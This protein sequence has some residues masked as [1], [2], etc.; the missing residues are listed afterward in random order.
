MAL[1]LVTFAAFSFLPLR[2]QLPAQ[3]QQPYPLD[4]VRMLASPS[5]IDLSFLLDA[6]AGKRGFLRVANGH[7][8]TADGKR[9]RLWGVNITDWSPGSR[10]IPDKADA[11]FWAQVLARFGV[12]CVRLQFLDLTTPRGLIVPD[13]ADTRMLDADQLDREDYFIAQLEQ[14]GIYIDFNLLVGRPFKAGDGVAD[15]DRLHEGAKGTSLFDHRLIELQQEY[16][17]QLLTH[18]NPYTGHAYSDDPAV[19]IVEVNNENAINVGYRAPSRFYADELEKLYNQWLAE[20]RSPEQILQLRTLASVPD[21]SAQVPLL[22][23][24]WQAASAPSERFQTE[25]AFFNDLQH[26]YF[27]AMRIFLQQTLSVHSLIIATADHSHSGS[28]YPILMATQDNDIIDG[29]TYWQ[30]PEMYIHKSPMVD[31]PFNSTVVELSR[32]AIAGKPYTVS[33]VNNAFPNNY[34]AEGIPVL[35]A[36]GALQDWDAILWYTFEPKQ[37][38]NAAPYV[39]DPFDISQHPVKMAEL[40]ADAL[41]FLRSDVQPAKTTVTRTYSEDQVFD[42]MLLPT[43]DRPYFTPGFPLSLPIQDA[44][45]IASFDAP[46]TRK[47]PA[48]MSASPIRSDTHQLAW[49]YGATHSGLVSVDTPRTQAL[50][51]FL[52]AHPEAANANVSALIHNPFAALQVTALDGDSIAD[53]HRLLVVA[54]AAVANSGATWNAVG[55]A[56]TNWGKA[57]VTID[58]VRGQLMLHHLVGARLVTLTALD[59]AA[60]PMRQPVVAT[61]SGAVWTLSLDRVTPWYLVTVTR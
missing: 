57:P 59:G 47:F 9:I 24:R 31:D 33:E 42:S 7:L 12:N 55:T 56:L 20:H 48:A 43:M 41:L 25:A 19:A 36:Y 44:V 26:S 11:A 16:A 5:S 32:S 54:G 2:A 37:S 52:I 4:Y 22:T 58:P 28:G 45:R 50:I 34:D 1:A 40:A 21:A 53:A 3:T 38:R 51:G 29:H 39:G 35:A 23:S 27:D 60:Q 15:A 18:R 30:H 8:A 17:R 49:Y 6:P 13:R 14:R 46:I 10:Q 61:H